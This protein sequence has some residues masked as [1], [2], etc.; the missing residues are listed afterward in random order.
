VIHATQANPA[1]QTLSHCDRAS[2]LLSEAA[3]SAAEL[4]RAAEHDGAAN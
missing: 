4:T 2:K 3:P 1:R